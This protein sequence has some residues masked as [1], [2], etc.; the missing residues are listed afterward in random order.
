MKGLDCKI[1]NVSPEIARKWLFNN[2]VNRNI[3]QSRVEAYAYDMKENKWQ[4]NGEAIKIGLDGSL[5]DGQHRL[6]AVIKA[7]KSIPMLVIYGL[8]EDI[9]IQD[10]G[11]NRSVT[12]SL[13]LEGMNGKIANNR[14]VAIAKL[15]FSMK[16]NKYISDYQIKEFI[17]EHQDT[18]LKVSRMTHQGG[19]PK[20]LRIPIASACIGLAL[21]T[22]LEVG[23]P[24][25][26]L[27]RWCE[28]VKTGIQENANEQ[29]AI[30]FRNDLIANNVSTHTSTA[31]KKAVYQTEK[32]ISDF[33]DKY[34]R[35][36]SYINIDNPVYSNYKTKE[37]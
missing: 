32:S 9:T 29:A 26:E 10:R 12:D 35:K 15:H 11:R 3:C 24:E 20:G 22:A 37:E 4:L 23:Y 33:H 17:I 30:I 16:S 25:D 7:N 34:K 5:K 2:K 1:V 28:V 31:R 21:M 14:N 19:S 27:K 18:L 6:S 36:V 8:T 13:L